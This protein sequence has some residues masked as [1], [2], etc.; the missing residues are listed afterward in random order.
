MF[1]PRQRDDTFTPQALGELVEEKRIE[2]VTRADKLY[3]YYKGKNPGI[4]SRKAPDSDAPDHKVPVPY[5]RKIVNTMT[6]Y[7]YKPGLI[8]YNPPIEANEKMVLYAKEIGEIFKKNSEPLKT[9]RLGKISSIYGEA[10]EIHF[11]KWAVDAT[12]EPRFAPVDPQE[13]ILVYNY[14]IEPEVMAGIRFWSESAEITWI[15]LWKWNTKVL[16]KMVKKNW[17]QTSN[18]LSSKYEVTQ[19]GEPEEH[20]Y[21]EVPIVPFYNNDE[22]EGDFEPVIPLID[23]FDLVVT[24]SMNEFDRFAWA[25]LLMKAVKADDKTLRMIKRRRVFQNLQDTNDIKFLTKQIQDEFIKDLR[26]SMRQQ[27]HMQSHVPDFTDERFKG[28]IS[29]AAIKR[30]LFDFENLAAT[31]QAY[32]EE[33]LKKRLRLIGRIQ[34]LKG[35]DEEAM[36]TEIKFHRN[37]PADLAEAAQTAAQMLATVSH[38][39]ALKV[40][41]ADIVPD[42]DKEL[43]QIEAEGEKIAIDVD[44]NNFPEPP[45]EGAKDE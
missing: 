40:Y 29:G 9:S 18:L 21:G 42:I 14:A 30:L 6:G 17:Q 24:D 33:G 13:V 22:W 45:E 35:V 44:E 26:G 1:K 31:K 12:A 19:E 23:A 41:P 7:M 37:L 28:D 4:M 20:Y 25:Y 16:Y 38:R 32:F 11:T 3:K 36:Q 15:E 27:I 39:T 5:G 43:E 8:T 10:Y 34:G 2:N